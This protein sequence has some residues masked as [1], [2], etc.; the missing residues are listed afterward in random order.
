MKDIEFVGFICGYIAMKRTAWLGEENTAEGFMDTFTQR[1]N[2]HNDE[3]QKH[4]EKMDRKTE[5]PV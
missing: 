2:E 1:W 5:E 4:V 3:I